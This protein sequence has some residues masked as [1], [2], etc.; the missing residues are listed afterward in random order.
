MALIIV[1]TDAPLGVRM[2]RDLR[3]AA[4]PG[5]GGG[6]TTHLVKCCPLAFG[7]A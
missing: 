6:A 1:S 5:E 4:G 2:R 7:E 3:R